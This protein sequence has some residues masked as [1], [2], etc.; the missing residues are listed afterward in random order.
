M[1]DDNED[2]QL[3]LDSSQFGRLMEAERF[4]FVLT[5]LVLIL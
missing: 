3:A 2:G 1:Q 4:F 5:L